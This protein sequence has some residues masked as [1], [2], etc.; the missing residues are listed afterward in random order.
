[1]DKIFSLE[2][3]VGGVCVLL[4]IMV[5]MKVGEFVWSVREK[6]ESLSESAI[7]ELTKAVQQNTVALQFLEMRLKALE[8]SVTEFPKLKNDI[9]RFYT[10]M[11]EIA[12]E[13]WADIRDEIMKDGFNV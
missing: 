11:K 7:T 6:R 4:T 13:R 2:Y 10:A 8:L 5:L 1:M 9:R 12:G 3:G